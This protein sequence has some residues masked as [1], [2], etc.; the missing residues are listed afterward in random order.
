MSSPGHLL[1]SSFHGPAWLTGGSVGPEGS[2][3]VFVMIAGLWIAFDRTYHEVR[4]PG[5]AVSRE[6]PR[7]APERRGQACL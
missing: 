2:V 3:L 7:T 4:Y 5:L 1:S 6:V